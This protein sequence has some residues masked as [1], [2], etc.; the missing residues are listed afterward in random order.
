LIKDIE[1]DGL[2]QLPLCLPETLTNE[3]VQNKIQ[4]KRAYVAGWGFTKNPG[5]CFTNN[6]GP[7]R[8][9]KCRKY[10]FDTNRKVREGCIQSSTPSSLNKRCKQ[11][12]MANPHEYPKCPAQSIKII[13]KHKTKE[14]QCYA[15]SAL[16]HSAN[17]HGWCGTCNPDA[18]IGERGYC[19][20]TGSEDEAEND[21]KEN[22]IVQTNRNWGFCSPFCSPDYDYF[23]KTLQETTITILTDEECKVF[24]NDTNLE[25]RESLKFVAGDELCAA[26][27]IPFPKMK[28]Y[29]RKKKHEKDNGYDGLKYK[30]KYTKTIPN[31][32]DTKGAKANM[33]YYLGR[34]NSCQ[35]GAGGPLWQYIDKRATIV[36]VASRGEDCAAFNSPGIYTNIQKHLK[37]IKETISDY[38]C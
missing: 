35:G 32:F 15:H 23:T 31:K 33:D 29:E 26:L 27:K 5:S 17:S 25:L 24:A 8:H 18:A 14:I 9:V 1:I 12:A 11:F 37:W 20:Y 13:Y 28:V 34:T 21:S 16:D 19:P 3:Q 2:R 36:G 6:F 38:E 4:N 22:T 10:F 7:D 30:F